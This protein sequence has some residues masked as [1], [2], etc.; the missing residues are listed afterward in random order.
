[1]LGMVHKSSH[2]PENRRTLKSKQPAIKKTRQEDTTCA[3][4][5]RHFLLILFEL[6]KSSARDNRVVLPSIFKDCSH[7]CEFISHPS[8]LPRVLEIAIRTAIAKRGV[9]VIV[10]SGDTA[11]Q[12]ATLRR[13]AMKIDSMQPKTFPKME[14]LSRAAEIL[15]EGSRVTIFGGAGCMGSHAELL[16]NWGQVESSHCPRSPGQGI[17]RIR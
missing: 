1:M 15:N 5:P 11:L 10:I 17:H 6:S 7:Y 8:Q 2:S 9:A 16:E 12:E 13:I 14:L 4:T 3:Y